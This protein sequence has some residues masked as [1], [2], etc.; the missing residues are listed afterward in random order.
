MKDVTQKFTLRTIFLIPLALLFG[1][2]WPSE[3]QNREHQ[4]LMADIYGARDSERALGPWSVSRSSWV[5][6][7]EPSRDGVQGCVTGLLGVLPSGLRVRALMDQPAERRGHDQRVPVR[8]KEHASPD[9]GAAN[10]V[11]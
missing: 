4:Q 6:S 10:V 7:G 11:P 2:A 9:E 3:A 5:L 8:A 1:L